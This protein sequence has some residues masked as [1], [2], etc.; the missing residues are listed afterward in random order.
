MVI[1]ALHLYKQNEKNSCSFFLIGFIITTFSSL[2]GTSSFFNAIGRQ[3]LFFFFLS[4]SHYCRVGRRIESSDMHIY[5]RMNK[6]N[7]ARTKIQTSK[8]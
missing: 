2:Y 7:E 3:K 4:V 8:E 1:C 5:E 6:K